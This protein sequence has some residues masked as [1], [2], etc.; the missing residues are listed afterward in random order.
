MDNVIHVDRGDW[1]LMRRLKGS[2][3]YYASQRDSRY[4]VAREKEISILK[5]TMRK[6]VCA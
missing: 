6:V 4:D 5:D 2:L 1:L 3:N